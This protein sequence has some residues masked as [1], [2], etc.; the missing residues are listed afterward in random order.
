MDLLQV[1]TRRRFLVHQLANLLCLLLLA[2]ATLRAQQT[3]GSAVGTVT[4]NTGAVVS[5]ATVTLTDV[6]TGDRRTATT[7]SSW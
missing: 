1:S 4:D 7:N 3:S 2:T 5:G 6:D